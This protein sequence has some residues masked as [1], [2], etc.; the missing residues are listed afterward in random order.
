MIV[1]T[2]EAVIEKKTQLSGFHMHR[3]SYIALLVGVMKTLDACSYVKSDVFK[4]DLS[5]RRNVF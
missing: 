1:H 5:S 3:A 2:A 4:G